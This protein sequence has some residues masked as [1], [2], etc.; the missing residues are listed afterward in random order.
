MISTNHKDEKRNLMNFR[1]NCNFGPYG[2]FFLLHI[3]DTYKISLQENLNGE[4]K[5]STLLSFEKKKN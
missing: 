3:F 2:M 1:V 5:M 4:N